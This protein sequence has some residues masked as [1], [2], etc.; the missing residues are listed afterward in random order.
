MK[1]CRKCRLLVKVREMVI[2]GDSRYCPNCM[3]DMDK[4]SYPDPSHKRLRPED[5]VEIE[6]MRDKIW[7]RDVMMPWPREKLEV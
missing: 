3:A 4:V 5:I 6:K 2:E 7:A 1:Q